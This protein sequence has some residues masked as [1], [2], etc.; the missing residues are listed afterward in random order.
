MELRKEGT[1]L[2]NRLAFQHLG[3]QRSRRGRNRAAAALERD[4]GDM[5]AIERQIDRYP[6]AA[7]RVVAM[8]KM[9]RLLDLAKVARVAPVIEDDV[10]IEF[11]Q[12]DHRRNTSRA[13]SIASANR[14]MSRSSL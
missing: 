14:S 7:Q 13:A 5:V 1:G 6:V 8:S 3:H 12:I 11:A 2:F 10:L 9:R 4:V